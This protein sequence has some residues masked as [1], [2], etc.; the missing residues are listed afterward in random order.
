MGQ[1][2]LSESHPETCP[3]DGRVIFHQGFQFLMIQQIGIPLPDIRIGQHLMDFQ[4]SGFHP[5]S[6]F[7]IPSVLGNLTDIDFRI[8]IGGKC[9]SVITGITIHYIQVL[10]FIKMMFRSISCKNSRYSRVKPAPQ[11]GC[12]SFFFKAVVVCPLP[13][14][15]EMCHI[16][17]FII[18]CIQIIHPTFQTSF[19]DRQI[20]IRQGYVNHDSR[21][22]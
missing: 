10:D 7:I 5:V 16:F 4:W 6:V 8:E 20:L 19:H 21:L 18:S 1:V 3:L 14:V 13:A 15:F 22:E 12:Q 11:Y 2:F 9:L 17:R